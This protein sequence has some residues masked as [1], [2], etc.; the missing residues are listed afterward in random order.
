MPTAPPKESD[1]RAFRGQTCQAEALAP[2]VLASI[3]REAIE[4]RLNRRALDQVL[5]RERKVRRE[6]IAKLVP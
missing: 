1:K 5:R 3:L 2:N 6:L 4:A